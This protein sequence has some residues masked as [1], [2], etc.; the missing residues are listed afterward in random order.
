MRSTGL[1][2]L[3]VVALAL[4]VLAHVI[5]VARLTLRPGVLGVDWGQLG[6]ACF[7]VMAGSFALGGR[8]TLGAW[9]VDRVLRLFPAYWLVTLAAF[10]ANAVVDYKPATVGLFVSQMLG[11]GYFTHGGASL[12]NVPSWFLSLIVACYAVAAVVRASRAPRATVGAMIAVTVALVALGVHSD[13]TRQVLAF[14]LGMAVRQAGLLERPAAV[15]ASIALAGAGAILIAP[16]FAYAGWGLAAFL[17]FAALPLPGWRPVRFVSDV[18]YEAFLVHGPV[19]VLVARVLPRAL[20]L[21]WPL[22]LL[23]GVVL[24][25]AAAVTLRETARLLTGLAWPAPSARA[26]RRA[27]TATVLAL[28]LWPVAATAQVGGLTALP[29]AEAP[30]PNLLKNPEPD[31]TGQWNL[32]PGGDVWVVD[33]TARDGKPAFKMANATRQQYVPGAEQTV[34]L[35]PGLYTIEGWVKTAG[36]GANDPRSGV[37]L[38]LDARPTGDWWQCTDVVRGTA[39]WTRVRL[40]SIPVKERGAYKFAFGAYGAPDGTAWF[41]GLSLR[42]AGKRLLDVYLLYPNFRG[43][44]FD[45]RPQTV[46]V[47]VAAGGGATG[48]VRLSLVDEAGGQVR[49]TREVPAAASA[50]VEL[51]AAGVPLGRYLLRAELVDAGGTVSGRYPDYRIVKLAAKARER[52]N[53]W[54]D[55]RNVLHVGGKPQFVLGLYNT[56]GY[57]TTRS[58]YASGD[59]GWGN[60]RISEAPVNM[61]INYHLGAAPIP[62]LNAYLDDLHARGIRYL[63]TVNFYRPADDLYKHLE[64]PAAKQG[65]DALNRWVADTLGKH[66]GLAGF[67]TMDERPAE[68]VPL[69]FRQYKHLAAGAPGTVTYGVLGD[70]WEAQAPLWRDALDVMGLDPYPITKPAGQNHLAMVGDWT[71][72][73]QDAVKRSRPVWMVLQYFPVT[74]AAGWPSEAELRAM[75]WMAIIEGARGLLYWSFGEKGLAWIKD[76]KEKAAKWAEL[77]RVTKEIKA[78]EPVL[79]A[80]DA[81]LVARETSGGTVRTLG[82]AM[83]DGRYLFAYNT[84]NTPTRVTWTLAAPAAETFDLATG[85]PGPRVESTTLTVELAPY[86]VRRLRVR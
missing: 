72:L 63:Q 2:A 54:Y 65:E 7:C 11:L 1:D 32:Q 22:T 55:E 42:G 73:G 53:V 24:A 81:A 85:K 27:G 25:L 84:R 79:L 35:E 39:D 51:D 23:L 86:E 17:L 20:P 29:E 38:C 48:R 77:V 76:P 4:V 80:P 10:G 75:S 9:L 57:S 78:L 60:D 31:G 58:S 56:S 50:T 40:P 15:Q 71:R 18:S 12:V 68:Q 16:N 14:L 44:L 69:V 82:K 46:R 64:Y 67:Y 59:N 30:G 28:A 49:A 61:L 34:T 47:A 83:P 52:F 21:P 13:F 26:V 45:D 33:R 43:I 74:S 62:A 41:N 66:P 5:E 3:R 19:V 36:L 8:R 6:V 70:G 37:R